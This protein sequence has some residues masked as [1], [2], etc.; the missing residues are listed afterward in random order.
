MAKNEHDNSAPTPKGKGAFN[1][2]TGEFL[3]AEDLAKMQADPLLTI[4]SAVVNGTL[5]EVPREI[6]TA[7]LEKAISGMDPRDVIAATVDRYGV[8][9]A[10]AFAVN[11]LTGDLR[12]AMLQRIMHLQKPWAQMTEEEQ[13]DQIAGVSA[14]A[15]CS[16]ANVKADGIEVK[17]TISR[18]AEE[19]HVLLD[20]VGSPVFITPAE[21]A[22][23]IGE[24]APAKPTPNQSSIP[25][26]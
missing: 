10:E 19:R 7:G 5:G 12:D 14:A 8:G 15:V 2:K 11:T 23:F 1:P 6:V 13:G 16:S 26:T 9:S 4:A 22:E 21:V 3:S 17:L 20:A 18:S 24:R 25:G